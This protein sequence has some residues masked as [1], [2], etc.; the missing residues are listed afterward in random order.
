VRTKKTIDVVLIGE[1]GEETPVSF[2]AHFEICPS[3]NGEGATSR[4]AECDGGG[5]TASEWA[6]QDD[7]FK[8]GYLAGDYDRPCEDCQETPGRILVLDREACDAKLLA[9]FDQQSADNAQIDR[10]M[11]QERDAERRMGC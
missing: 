4:A 8:E 7:D 9:L 3:C 10:E 5:F 11:R 1:D 2:P 6:E